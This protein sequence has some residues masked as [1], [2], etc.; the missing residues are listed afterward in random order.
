[1]NQFKGKHKN[2]MKII[3]DKQK[4]KTSTEIYLTAENKVCEREVWLSLSKE[5]HNKIKAI[6]IAG[7]PGKHRSRKNSNKLE[8]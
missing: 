8:S 1:M 2:T 7:I 3:R 6:Y 4:S 5:N